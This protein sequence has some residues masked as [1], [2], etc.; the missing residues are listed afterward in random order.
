MMFLHQLAP[1]ITDFDGVCFSLVNC[2]IGRDG[3]YCI[4]TEPE[5]VLGKSLKLS[6]S[7][8]VPNIKKYFETHGLQTDVPVVAYQNEIHEAKH[9]PLL[10][11]LLINLLP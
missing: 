7:H 9:W 8:S 6:L 5:I 2:F 11:R 4:L 10:S 1:D 3:P